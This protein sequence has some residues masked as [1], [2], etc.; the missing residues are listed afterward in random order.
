MTD[1]SDDF[2]VEYEAPDTDLTFDNWCDEPC[3]GCK[4]E[5]RAIDNGVCHRGKRLAYMECWEG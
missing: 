5:D 2:M 3:T 1:K 4:H